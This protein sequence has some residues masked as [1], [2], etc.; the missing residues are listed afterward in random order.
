MRDLIYQ[1]IDLS[2]FKLL[3]NPTTKDTEYDVIQ[4]EIQLKCINKPYKTI[5]Q[6][7]Q[8]DV[9]NVI[10]ALKYKHGL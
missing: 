2:L 10:N 4:V 3:N 5:Q 9:P 8:V 7:F 1:L 6:S